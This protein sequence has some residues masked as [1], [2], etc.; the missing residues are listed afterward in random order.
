MG[1]SVFLIWRTGLAES[2]VRGALGLFGVQLIFNVL[3]SVLFFGLRSPLAGLIDIAVLWVAI[4]LT[5]F[6][7]L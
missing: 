6:L 7:F 3:W 4:A 5:I 1:I 2:K